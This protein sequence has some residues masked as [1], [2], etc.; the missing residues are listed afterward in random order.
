M[1]DILPFLIFLAGLGQ[2][3]VLIAS[4]LVPFQ[5]DWKTTLQCLPRLHRQMYWVYGG[6]V[7]LAIVAFS[8]LSLLNA[9][10]LAS[11]SGLGRSISA[12]IAIF[13]GVRVFLQGR[14]DAKPYLTA[15]WLRLG[16][17]LL[18]MLFVGFTL[19]YGV[20]ALWPGAGA[21]CASVESAS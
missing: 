3:S 15:W 17:H 19:I 4:A 8:L 16:Y 6:Y 9:R 5:L 18:T 7:V 10:D 2:L 13:W 14:F 1:H 12:Y 11:G 20:A 21:G